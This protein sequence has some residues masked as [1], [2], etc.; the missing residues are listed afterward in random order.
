MKIL[1]LI[2]LLICGHKTCASS[3]QER[4][5]GGVELPIHLTPWLASIVVHGNY[6]C[7]SALITSQWLVTAGHCVH[8]PDSYSVRAGSTFT[9]EGGQRRDVVSVILHPDLNLRTLEN[10]IALL[11]IGKPFSLGANIQVVKLPGLNILPRTL[12]VAGWGYQDATDSESE[13]RLR[14]TM[15]EVID[16]RRCQRL[17]S[18]LHRPITDDM[19]CAAAAGRDHCYGDSGAPLVHRG[20]SYGIVSFAH[21]CAD[22]H[23][24]GVYTRL[25][26]YVTW[27]FNVLESDWK[28]NVAY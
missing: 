26:N 2:L 1:A 7:T 17:Y 3:T 23:F 4:I 21:G 25:A 8:Y 13:P 22:P 10:D 11:K 5:V 28:M 24:P 18:H 19:V 12:W 9:D 16:L 20:I 6:S 27:I 15:V 14:G